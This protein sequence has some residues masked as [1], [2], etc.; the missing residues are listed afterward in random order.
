[1]IDLKRI[2][3]NLE[4]VAELLSRKG[5]NADFSELIELDKERRTAIGEV[6]NLKAQRN[7]VS[8][9]IPALK[10]AGQ[11]ATSLRV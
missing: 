4:K 1:M 5:F 2:L 9:Q 7:K 8:A 3:E 11:K 6:E 10:K